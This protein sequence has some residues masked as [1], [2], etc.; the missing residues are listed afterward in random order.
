MGRVGMHEKNAIQ[1]ARDKGV[2]RNLKLQKRTAISTD[3][4]WDGDQSSFP[5]IKE[6][7]E[8]HLLQCGMSYIIHPKFIQ[9][10]REEGEDEAFATIPIG[11]DITREQFDHDRTVLYGMMKSVFRRPQ[12]K[13]YHI[14][15]YD[16]TDGIKTFDDI[17]TTNGLGGG[18]RGPNRQT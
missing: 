12:C 3:L 4:I 6:R 2:Y 11:M 7:I 5:E 18:Y 1:N 14:R 17:V 16:T 8:G 15:H 13:K 10:Y 9:I